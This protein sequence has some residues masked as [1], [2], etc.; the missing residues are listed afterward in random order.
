[1]AKFFLVLATIADLVLAALLSV[2]ARKA[3]MREPWQLSA[4]LSR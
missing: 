1:V 3:R 4:M 2:V